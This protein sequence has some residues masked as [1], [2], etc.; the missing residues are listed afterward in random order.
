M[1]TVAGKTFGI[2]ADQVDAA[3]QIT[4]R[5]ATLLRRPASGLRDLVDTM[6]GAYREAV[7]DK[8]YPRWDP[9]VADSKRTAQY[10]QSQAGTDYLT[11]FTFCSAVYTLTKEA[12]IKPG[13]WD[14]VVANRQAEARTRDVVSAVRRMIAP[15]TEGA[16]DVGA[17]VFSAIK[18]ILL[19]GAIGL[20]AIVAVKFLP[21]QKG[22]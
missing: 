17:G 4:T 21:K 18:P 14:P 6:M 22:A 13:V 12:A 5:L 15:A 19:L 16:K 20:A 8:G 1:I 7:V 11:A 3:R 2:G 9:K 10:V